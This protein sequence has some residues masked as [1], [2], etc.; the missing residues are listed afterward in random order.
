M[1]HHIINRYS[2]C[3]KISSS[4]IKWLALSFEPGMGRD[5]YDH[6]LEINTPAVRYLRLEDHVS[7]RISAG[8][9]NSLVEADIW[10]NNDKVNDDDLYSHSVFEFIEK[11]SQFLDSVFGLATLM[12][13]NL[14]KLELG[15]DWRF[16]MKFLDSA[17]NLEIFIISDVDEELKRWM[18]PQVGPMC[19]SSRLRQVT[20]NSFGCSEDEFKMVSYILKNAK[21]L[22]MMDI[23]AQYLGCEFEAK[24]KALHRISLM[25]RASD[26]FK[27]A[28]F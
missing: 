1:V 5:F 13:N 6:K 7:E 12:F 10:L 20:I 14:T 3:D 23:Y 2:V 25:E 22:N 9:M 15:A 18:E 16:L 17:D 21:L 27:L 26:T 11:L 19:L 8:T 28:F 4:T 24:F